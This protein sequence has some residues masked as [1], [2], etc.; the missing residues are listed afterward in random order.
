M[1]IFMTSSQ[2]IKEILA[3][4][5]NIQ[6]G[7][8][9]NSYSKGI[10]RVER[11]IERYY[12][13]S[14]PVLDDNKIGDKCKDRIIVSKRLLNSK[15]KKSLNYESC[16]EYFVKH[17]DSKQ[18]A[19]LE[20]ALT[21]KLTLLKEL[22]DYKI[23]TLINIYNSELQIDN[24][25]DLQTVLQLVESIKSGKTFLEIQNE[26]KRLD[27]LRLKPKYFGNYLFQLFN[28]DE[29]YLDKRRIWRDAKLTKK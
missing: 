4:N 26:L 10:Y 18:L 6:I 13:E 24:E 16:S 15:F 23:P 21:Q 20:K 12:D 8:W 11:I 1:V 7:D 22:D 17:L 2:H 19:E 27:I 25:N 14:C 28:F 3:M 5:Q 9:V 29:E